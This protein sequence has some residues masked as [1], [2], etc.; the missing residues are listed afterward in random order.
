MP[1]APKTVTATFFPSLG[2]SSPPIKLWW[3][4]MKRPPMMLRMTM[5]NN[6]MTMLSRD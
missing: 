3:L 1:T 6:E 5:A 4:F 2:S